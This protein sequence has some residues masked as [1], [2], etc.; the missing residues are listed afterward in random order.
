ML[1][2]SDD[3]ADGFKKAQR[4]ASRPEFRDYLRQRFPNK[5]EFADL[6]AI[7]AIIDHAEQIVD[8]F[9]ID[10]QAM[11]MICDLVV[12]YGPSFWSESWADVLQVPGL[13]KKE[14]YIMLRRRCAKWLNL[15]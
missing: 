12:M 4:K 8:Q 7:D 1:V 3:T 5:P 13:T 15:G 10:E 2:I 14:K 11:A 9:E 6:A